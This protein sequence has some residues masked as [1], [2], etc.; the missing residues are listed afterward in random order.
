MQ[1]YD[2][3][4]SLE[5]STLSGHDSVY[6][7]E[8]NFQHERYAP[9]GEAYPPGPHLPFD[10]VVLEHSPA[11]DRSKNWKGVNPAKRRVLAKRKHLRTAW[12]AAEERKK[13][14]ERQPV[15]GDVPVHPH[16][17]EENEEGV[18]EFIY[19]LHYNIEPPDEVDY[20]CAAEGFTYC[21]VSEEPSEE[22]NEVPVCYS[23]PMEVMDVTID[24]IL[25][26][27]R[28]YSDCTSVRALKDKCKNNP[29]GIF[30]KTVLRTKNLD[31]NDIEIPDIPEELANFRI[32]LAVKNNDAN[33]HSSS[34]RS[35]KKEIPHYSGLRN[36]TITQVEEI[37]NKDPIQRGSVLFVPIGIGGEHTDP[38][39]NIIHVKSLPTQ[40][41]NGKILRELANRGY[42]CVTHR[43]RDCDRNTVYVVPNR[44]R[45]SATMLAKTLQ[46]YRTIC[47]QFDLIKRTFARKFCLRNNQTLSDFLKFKMVRYKALC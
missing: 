14:E 35:N 33:S 4:L 19:P 15:Y 10:M 39:L 11:L 34:R 42:I 45:Y 21:E 22:F 30:E 40:Y 37:R 38:L 46:C 29:S 17:E 31:I 16:N 3:G 28:E 7:E 13:E 9:A 23:T 18:F 41:R 12:G 5:S 25:E 47:M 26:S 36:M 8:A 6:Y 24:C 44:T 20:G 27:R 2:S 1:R 32:P 43:L